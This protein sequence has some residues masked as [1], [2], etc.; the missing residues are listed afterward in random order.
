[1]SDDTAIYINSV[2][3][4]L[5]RPDSYV[6]SKSLIDNKEYYVTIS[7]GNIVSSHDTV[8]YS[9]VLLKIF[10][11]ILV[12][13]CDA[14]VNANK[15]VQTLYV[16]VDE[17]IRKI[18][19]RNVGSC[20]P[21]EE[22]SL[23][24]RT[25]DGNLVSST[26]KHWYPTML[27]SQLNY[28]TNFNDS[29]ERTTGGRN[30]LGAK[31]TNIYSTEFTVISCDGKQK[32][33]QSFNDN[34]NIAHAAVIKPS[35]KCVPYVEISF[36]YDEKYIVN[37]DV[38]PFN[39]SDTFNLVRKRVVD[40]AGIGK[41]SKV[42]LND[43]CVTDTVSNFT[44]LIKFYAPDASLFQ[45]KSSTDSAWEVY[46]SLGEVSSGLS[47]VNSIATTKGGTHVDIVVD[48]IKKL[49][50]ASIKD[51]KKDVTTMKRIMK[52]LTCFVNATV[53]NPTFSSQTKT[54]LNTSRTEMREGYVFNLKDQSA[55]KLVA[56]MKLK[57][58]EIYDSTVKNKADKENKKKKKSL[59][60]IKGLRDADYAGTNKAKDCCLILTEG[61]SAAGSCYAGLEKLSDEEKRH[62]GLYSMRGK[63]LN[64]SDATVGKVTGN[65]VITDIV[66]ALGLTYD[67]NNNKMRYGTI[68]IMTDQDPDGSHIKGLILN[69]FYKYW[70]S[71]IKDN[72]I[73]Q[74]IT[75]LIK[76]FD[77]KNKCI[78][79]FFSV[80]DFETFKSSC[81][82]I[83]K[84]KHQY[85]KGL[86][87]SQPK[88]FGEYF[89]NKHKYTKMLLSGTNDNEL[90]TL[91]FNKNNSNDRKSW[92]LKDYDENDY[93]EQ[94]IE[95]FINTDL[96]EY[97]L[98]A[99]VRAIP[100]IFDGLKPSQRKALYIACKKLNTFK[101]V[102][103][104]TSEVMTE[105]HYHHGDRS[106]SE[107]ITAMAQ[108]YPGA[109]NLPLL[110]GKG[111]F[112]TRAKHDAGAARYV[113]VGVPAYVT[114]LFPKEDLP[115]LEYNYDNDDQIEPVYMMPIIP[116]VLINGA[117]GIAT[118]WKTVIPSFNPINV[119]DACKK[120]LDR[121]ETKKNWKNGQVDLSDVVMTPWC[122]YYD[123]TA[124][125]V[126]A[127]GTFQSKT[128][129]TIVGKKLVVTEIP[130]NTET[131]SWYS[132]LLDAISEDDLS[133]SSPRLTVRKFNSTS[134]RFECVFNK[135]LKPELH[136]KL[137]NLLNA[138]EP[139]SYNN[140]NLVDEKSKVYKFTNPT[141]IIVAHGVR[142]LNVYTA[143]KKHMLNIIQENVTKT[144]NILRYIRQ[145]NNG[146]I[147]IKNKTDEQLR[148]LLDE[149]KYNRVNG[150]FQYILEKPVTVISREQQYE[151][152]L[153]NYKIEFNTV[154]DKT[155][156][157][158]WREELDALKHT[159]TCFDY[160]TCFG[161]D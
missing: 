113:Y 30:G 85:Y 43:I 79:E 75:P 77:T 8:K 92:M 60:S 46:C 142:R 80:K 90:F 153:E 44:E 154:S 152:A 101:Q 55:K 37:D 70:P 25:K 115:I 23:I 103:V 14:A 34:M 109:N 161:L 117:L 72:N 95:R 35:A 22:R 158:M 132:N 31:L 42:Y 19:V 105:T 39:P 48:S 17:T 6:G 141:S 151:R 118:G 76:I 122:R 94:S 160:D 3:H 99:I 106:L 137:F 104:F 93:V 119:I 15:A 4:I 82:D 140:M 134:M 20:I 136:P 73:Q 66:N 98:Y 81:S 51:N 116:T 114:K 156:Y 86:G 111:N 67:D 74:F 68:L 124:I 131:D 59:N 155:E 126:N 143:R 107:T 36:I 96:H 125:E 13:A 148:Q 150:S 57:Y 157:S 128:N 5:Q 10:D 9:P 65:D 139:L 49:L 144:G 97:S 1:M 16:T 84:Y 62:Y 130:I 29:V 149:K 40:T 45:L 127:K 56:E 28:S 27:F 83:N 47:Y 32:F 38:K 110:Q 87:T 135:E 121:H 108:W 147:D 2:N 133:F 63:I 78:N 53:V 24:E 102:A 54:Q 61:D 18:T 58:D 11:E 33:K 123:N 41:F 129:Y 21:I 52:D 26:E 88:E 7:N 69:L 120:F 145:V 100:C 159:L 12:N 112:G 50:D 146:T 91:C 71:L 64:V 89:V 138:V